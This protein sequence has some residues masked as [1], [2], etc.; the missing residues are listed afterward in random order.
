MPGTCK[1]CGKCCRYFCFEIDAP[2]DYEAYEDLRWFLLHGGVS[3]HIDEDGDWYIS[4]PLA[5]DALTDDNRCEIYPDRPLICRK[6]SAANC[7]RTGG[8][9]EYQEEFTT[10]EQIEAYAREQLGGRAFDGPRTRAKNKLDAA[11]VK[12]AEKA[13]RK[14]ERRRKKSK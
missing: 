5:C 10:P 13:R 2:E 11:L 9:Y 8:D 6:Y 7:D 12:A 14:R 1:S 3:I 4:I